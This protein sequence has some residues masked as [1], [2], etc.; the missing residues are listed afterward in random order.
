MILIDDSTNQ[1]IVRFTK[2]EKQG[3]ETQ[4]KSYSMQW[5]NPME[6]GSK[7]ILY[8]MEKTLQI[9]RDGSFS[10]LRFIP[11]IR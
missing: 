8:V 1:D 6:T 11:C 2:L 4:W 7:I 10:T 5:K 9:K 3:V